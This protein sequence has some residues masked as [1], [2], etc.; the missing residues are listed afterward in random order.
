MRTHVTILATLAALLGLGLVGATPTAQA[1][2]GAE[3]TR[4]WVYEVRIV[5]VDPSEAAASEAGSPFPELERTTIDLPW[6]TILARLKARGTTR[7]LMDTRITAMDGIKTHT[8]EEAST[9]IV[10]LN[11]EDWNNQQYRSQIIKQGCSFEQTTTGVLQYALQVRGTVTPPASRR[12][13][14]QYVVDWQ[15]THPVLDGRTLVL[16]HRQQVALPPP[17]APGPV[18]ERRLR[19]LLEQ[20]RKAMAQLAAKRDA[21][22]KRRA[23]LEKALAKVEGDDT[24]RAAVENALTA[25]RDH[26]EAIARELDAQHQRQAELRAAAGGPRDAPRSEGG[27]RR[28]GPPPSRAIEH[29]AFI[30]GRLVAN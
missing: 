27:P 18:G 10:A 25:N 17:G 3:G 8:R 6:K 5:R 20:H 1:E 9:P 30:T 21:L 11:F 7:V 14:A 22:T 4:V 2:D 23:E 12:P 28:G 15:G 19:G 29:Y 26:L 13:P 16:E 24:A